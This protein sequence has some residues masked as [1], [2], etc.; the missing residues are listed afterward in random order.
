[1]N[2]CPAIRVQGEAGQDG[3]RVEDDYAM[4]TDKTADGVAG[5]DADDGDAA[6]TTRSSHFCMGSTKLF[7]FNVCSQVEIQAV[8][9]AH[10]ILTSA[11]R[12]SGVT[13]YD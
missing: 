1:M 9:R 2:N 10:W 11:P 3:E 5:D 6:D 13:S 8:K 12:L 7:K 4:L